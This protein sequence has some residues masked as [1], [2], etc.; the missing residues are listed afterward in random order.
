MLEI[1]RGKTEK[2]KLVPIGIEVN[3]N[4]DKVII[5]DETN[6]C[7]KINALSPIDPGYYRALNA[8]IQRITTIKPSKKR[9]SVQKADSKGGILKKIEKEIANLDQ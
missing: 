8:A 7:E 4:L 5:A 3:D 6:I 9:L 2:P 1:I